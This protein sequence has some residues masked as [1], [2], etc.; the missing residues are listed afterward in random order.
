MEPERTYYDDGSIH[1]ELW[2]VNGKNHRLDGPA[3]ICY[4]EDGSI[5]YERWRVND[6]SHRIDGPAWISYNRDG[7]ISHER[8]AV[9]G[10]FIDD[11]IPWLEE[12]GISVPLS[13]EDLMAIKLRWM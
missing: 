11:I 7:S 1:W 9:N 13:D 10:M 12:N 5:R 2:V 4:H 8:W 6:V 3:E